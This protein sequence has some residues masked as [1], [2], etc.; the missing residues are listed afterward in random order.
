MVSSRCATTVQGV[1][2]H[3]RMY[4]RPVQL[5]GM[6]Q[7]YEMHCVLKGNAADADVYALGQHSW[8]AC[9]KFG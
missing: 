9:N 1:A 4:R 3:K 8:M 2:R 7:L 6:S 5:D